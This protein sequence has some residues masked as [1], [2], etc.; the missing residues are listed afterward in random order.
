MG[1]LA[2]EQFPQ[3]VK[4]NLKQLRQN[5][6]LEA[7]D[8]INWRQFLAETMDKS[9]MMREDK[10]QTA[11]HRFKR[12]DSKSI[13]LN[14][15]VQVLGGETQAQEIMGYVDTDGDG[16]ITFDDFFSAIKEE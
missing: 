10:V 12:S 11:F 14:D 5:L 4:E 7:T 9:I 13:H 15:L 3:E 16:K 8:K 1:A 6:K 2:D